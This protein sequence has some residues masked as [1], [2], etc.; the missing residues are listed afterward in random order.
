MERSRTTTQPPIVP[1]SEFYRNY[2]IGS[3]KFSDGT[4]NVP[5]QVVQNF[6]L[7]AGDQ[8]EW[9]PCATEFPDNLETDILALLIVRKAKRKEEPEEV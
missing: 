2:R 6:Q 1:K 9:Y 7:K 3:S 4:I 5:K 8:L